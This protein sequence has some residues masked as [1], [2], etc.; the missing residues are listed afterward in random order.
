MVNSQERKPER[1]GIEATDSANRV[2]E[3]DAGRILGRR[4]RE[5]PVAIAEDRVDVPVIEVDERFEVRLRP[6]DQLSIGQRAGFP[7]RHHREEMFLPRH[8]HAATPSPSAFCTGQRGSDSNVTE[9]AW[10]CIVGGVRGCGPVKF[11]EDR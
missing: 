7:I 10:A 9:C 11:T 4:P 2:Q 8:H 6:A 1:L 3:R 5:M